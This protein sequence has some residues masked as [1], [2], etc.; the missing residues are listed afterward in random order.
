MR[1]A[2]VEHDDANVKR[3]TSYPTPAFRRTALAPGLLAAV[4]LFAGFALVGTDGFIWVD[5]VISILALVIVVF[6]WQARQWWWIVALVPIAVIWNPVY[7]FAF[8]GSLWLGAQVVAALVFVL[9]GIFIT[10]VNPE[11]RNASRLT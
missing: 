3:M 4:V 8:E 11:D 9:A 1:G 6:A 2:N 7:P 10:I 5:Y